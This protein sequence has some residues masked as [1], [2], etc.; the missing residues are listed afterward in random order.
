MWRS[1]DFLRARKT[2]NRAKKV[3]IRECFAF[4]D[5]P[6]IRKEIDTAL[7]KIAY[8]IS[9][10]YEKKQNKENKGRARKELEERVR[11][12][13]SEIS[14][15]GRAGEKSSTTKWK[16]YMMK[17]ESYM[18]SYKNGNQGLRIGGRQGEW[19]YEERC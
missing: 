11:R 13:S 7:M 16:A 17:L 19:I 6:N 3:H 12:A 18:M 14:R 1:K 4:S 8:N 5:D 9:L 10:Q 2:A 15:N